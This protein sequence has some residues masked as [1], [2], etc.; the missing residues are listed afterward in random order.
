MAKKEFEVGETFQCGIVKL[1]CIIEPINRSERCDGCFF[2]DNGDCIDRFNNIVGECSHTNR[3][4]K[5]NVIFVKVED[6]EE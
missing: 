2:D 5:T 1:K 6:I 3:K 4:D